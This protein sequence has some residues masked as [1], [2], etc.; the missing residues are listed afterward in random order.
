[1]TETPNPGQATRASPYLYLL[2]KPFSVTVA[3]L[4][5]ILIQQVPSRCPAR[6]LSA[7]PRCVS[8]RRDAGVRGVLPLRAPPAPGHAMPYRAAFLI[9]DFNY[10]LREERGK[11][12]KPSNRFLSPVYFHKLLQKKARKVLMEVEA[13]IA[14]NTEAA[15]V[16]T[17]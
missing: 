12:K 13:E 9:A 14:S 17:F 2:P 15:G 7:R 8:R 16:Q 6:P 1:M 3:I 5:L 4:R 10:T 11:K